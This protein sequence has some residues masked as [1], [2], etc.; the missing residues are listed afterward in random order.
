[1]A[2]SAALLT[3]LT[4]FVLVYL[5]ATAFAPLQPYKNVI[6]ARHGDVLTLYALVL[7]LNVFSLWLL[8]VRRLG[9][10][11][12]G[13]KLHHLDQ[14]LRAGSHLADEIQRLDR[15]RDA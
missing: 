12:T 8:I 15:K 7:I 1:M 14:E 6:W 11:T 10:K 13:R 2:G 9:L 3:T 4:L 5:G